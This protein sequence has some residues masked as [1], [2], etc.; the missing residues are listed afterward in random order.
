MKDQ[1]QFKPAETELL[2]RIIVV[3]TS[4]G[5]QQ[6][7]DKLSSSSLIGVDLEGNLSHEGRIELVQMSQYDFK[8]NQAIIYVFDCLAINALDEIKQAVKSIME[9]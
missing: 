8:N 2:H 9:N 5:V 4:E 6:A 3:N 7:L 1:F